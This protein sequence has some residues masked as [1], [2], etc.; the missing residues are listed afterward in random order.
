MGQI[1]SEL[2]DVFR[3]IFDDDCLVI[4]GETTSTD[5]DGWDSIAH[6]NL[7]IAIERSFGIKFSASDLASMKETEQKVGNLVSLVTEKIAAKG[8]PA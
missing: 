7:I 6:I 5:I 8:E 3:R 1:L 4:G 2:Q